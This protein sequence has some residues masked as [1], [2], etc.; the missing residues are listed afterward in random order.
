M[1]LIEDGLGDVAM[2]ELDAECAEGEVDL[3]MPICR[4]LSIKK[5]IM[6]NLNNTQCL[7]IPNG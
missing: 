4:L 2:L 7:D 5:K 1:F 6:S 3:F